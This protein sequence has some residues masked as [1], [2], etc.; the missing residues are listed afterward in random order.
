MSWRDLSEV[1][2]HENRGSGVPLPTSW[3]PRK[4]GGVFR[5]LRAKC[6]VRLKGSKWEHGGG[7]GQN[8]LSCSGSQ[9]QGG[10]CHLPFSAFVRSLAN[11]MNVVP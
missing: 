11:R 4:A 9:V 6:S 5:S 10:K 1:L 7:G 8:I 2:A 3:R